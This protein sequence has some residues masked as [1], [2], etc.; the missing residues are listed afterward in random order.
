[1]TRRQSQ[2][3]GRSSGPSRDSHHGDRVSSYPSRPRMNRASS[4]EQTTYYTS[5]VSSP[6]APGIYGYVLTIVTSTPRRPPS[7]R[8]H[9][10]PQQ[11]PQYIQVPRSSRADN[12]HPV[13]G[14]SNS[15]SGIHP[16]PSR[17]QARPS[18]ARHSNSA[19][20]PSSS[21]PSPRAW[22]SRYNPFSGTFSTA[23]T[24]QPRLTAATLERL[25]RHQSPDLDSMRRRER[26]DERAGP[27]HAIGYVRRDGEVF[28]ED[29]V[30]EEYREYEYGDAT[31]EEWY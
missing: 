9:Y 21:A 16:S 27:Y 6:Q 3:G 10:D 15:A 1:M 11:D 29:E 26:E 22:T 31:N 8:D 30:Y 25:E 24:N 5:E 4:H 7:E 20:L 17:S 19:V 23:Q 12:L 28:D 13:G 18:D 2:S 14:V